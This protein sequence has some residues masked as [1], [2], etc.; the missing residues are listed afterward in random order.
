MKEKLR[1]GGGSATV[2]VA[3]GDDRLGYEKSSVAAR[4]ICGTGGTSS[5]GFEGERLCDLLRPL[6]PIRL[7]MK[8]PMEEL[9]RPRGSIS[10]ESEETDMEVSGL[11]CISMTSER[12]LHPALVPLRAGTNTATKL[13][14]ACPIVL[15]EVGGRLLSTCRPSV[16]LASI[17]FA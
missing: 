11:A 17:V 16:Q 14:E 2:L 3:M 9:L 1:N 10:V 8:P 6:E 15:L 4:R 13:L 7:R 12:A 5:A